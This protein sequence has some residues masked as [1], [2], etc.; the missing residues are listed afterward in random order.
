IFLARNLTAILDREMTGVE[1][2]VQV[3]A[4]SPDLL[5]GD[6]AGFHQRARDA[7][8]FQIVDSY[9]LTDKDGHQVVNT[10]VPYGTALP[11]SGVSQE[12]TR[13]FRAREP[14]LS[15]LFTG[16]VSRGPVIALGVPVVRGDEVIYSLNVGLSPERIGNV[17]G[18]R[19]LPEGWVAAVLDRSGT[20]IARTRDAER[21]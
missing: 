5:A 15:S 7:I 13:V 19:G 16:A 8:K 1:A 4:S 14:V 21:Y 17:L 12:L 18:R 2:G 9:V 11:S 20:I 10:L 3:L 6:L